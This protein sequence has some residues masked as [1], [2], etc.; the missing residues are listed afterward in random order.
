MEYS[1]SSDDE[2][3]WDKLKVSKNTMEEDKLETLTD[4]QDDIE[5][6]MTVD[7][8]MAMTRLLEKKI[9]MLEREQEERDRIG[10]LPY[11]H[12]FSRRYTRY[13]PRYRRD[14]PVYRP[15]RPTYHGTFAPTCNGCGVR[16][17]IVRNCPKNICLPIIPDQTRKTR[18]TQLVG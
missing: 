7:E 3:E 14:R 8:M 2:Y 10:Y 16:G 15:R 1:S 12:T 5:D 13:Y 17:H 11:E 18:D 9:E 4:I 6:D